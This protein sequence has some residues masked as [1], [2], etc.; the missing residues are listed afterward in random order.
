MPSRP[1]DYTDTSLQSFSP[2]RH[3]SDSFSPHWQGPRVISFDLVRMRAYGHPWKFGIDPQQS[4]EFVE[5][6]GFGVLSDLDAK[7]LAR[8]YLTR[9]DGTID[10]LPTAYV[11]IMHAVIK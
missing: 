9:S 5:A 1:S 11:R 7:Q 10:G 3:V 6:R 4:A 8:R 2:G